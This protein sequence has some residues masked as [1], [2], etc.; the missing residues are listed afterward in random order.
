MKKKE[1]AIYND[2][3]IATGWLLNCTEKQNIEHFSGYRIEKNQLSSA[4]KRTLLMLVNCCGK[5]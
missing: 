5:I 1:Y 2:K 4:N 3:S